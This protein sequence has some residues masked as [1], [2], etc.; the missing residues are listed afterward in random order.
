MNPRVLITSYLGVV[1]VHDQLL[2]VE[3][4]TGFAGSSTVVGPAFFQ[5]SGGA[6]RAPSGRLYIAGSG[7]LVH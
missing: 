4:P 2:L 5:P 6:W 3:W 7:L 1:N